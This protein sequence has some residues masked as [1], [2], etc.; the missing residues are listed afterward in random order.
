MTHLSPLTH[1]AQNN[2]F[3]VLQYLGGMASHEEGLSFMG[4]LLTHDHNLKLMGVHFVQKVPSNALLCL[5]YQA[6]DALLPNSS[7][8]QQ[9]VPFRHVPAHCISPVDP[10]FLDPALP[11][12]LFGGLRMWPS[13]QN[14]GWIGGI[15]C[16][17]V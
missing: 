11:L 13:S 7:L 12:F 6:F 2:A 14:A 3:G 8:E 17:K 5:K 15:M 1:Q 9:I 10:P 4:S 16:M